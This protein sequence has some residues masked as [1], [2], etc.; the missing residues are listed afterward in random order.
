M[1]ESWLDAIF[2]QIG[3]LYSTFFIMYFIENYNRP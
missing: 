2:M 3:V 1:A